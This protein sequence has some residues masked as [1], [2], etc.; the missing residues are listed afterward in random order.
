MTYGTVA[1]MD[2]AIGLA[3]IV[4]LIVAVPAIVKW[5]NSPSTKRKRVQA[6]ENYLRDIQNDQ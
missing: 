5:G 2:F 3:V 6:R 1:R 4:V